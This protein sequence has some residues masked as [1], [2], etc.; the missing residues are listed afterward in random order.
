MTSNEHTMSRSTPVK[1]EPHAANRRRILLVDDDHEIAESVSYALQACGYEVLIAR[2][3]NQGLAMAEREDPDLVILDM[4]MPKRSG[5]LVLEKLRRTRPVPLRVIMITANEGSRHMAY[6]EMLG[7]DDYIRKPFAMD[8]L[9]QSVARLFDDDLPKRQANTYPSWQQISDLDRSQTTTFA[10]RSH[11][12]MGGS[13]FLTLMTAAFAEIVGGFCHDIRNRISGLSLAIEEPDSR[14]QRIRKRA[15]DAGEVVL[16]LHQFA[17]NYYRSASD[18]LVAIPSDS[19]HSAIRELMDQV[20]DG[21]SIEP[22]VRVVGLAKGFSIPKALLRQLLAPLVENASE[23]L[24]TRQVKGCIAVEIR[25]FPDDAIRITV[26]DNGPGWNQPVQTIEQQLVAERPFSTK[27]THRGHGLVN[28][29]RVVR[30]IRGGLSIDTAL[31]GGARIEITVRREDAIPVVDLRSI[32]PALTTAIA[33][34]TGAF[35]H[36][37]ANNLH[38]VVVESDNDRRD[39]A[40][41]Q[42][43]VRQATNAVIDLHQF[44][45]QHYRPDAVPI[46]HVPAIDIAVHLREILAPLTNGS[47]VEV[48][49]DTTELDRRLLF[50]RVLLRHL[51]LPIVENS[52]E[53]MFSTKTKG[54]VSVKLTSPVPV[55]DVMLSIKD[56]GPGFGEFLETLRQRNLQ[57]EAFSTKDKARGHGLQNLSRLVDRM[58]GELSVGDAE[59]GGALVSAV[60]P[61]E[62]F[63]AAASSVSA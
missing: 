29:S 49:I 37:V 24:S 23:A 35:C 54:I 43:C 47:S 28:L 53:A 2:D 52:V 50:P 15:L 21:Y 36:D 11:R 62:V 38:G 59:S 58:N 44:V 20:V 46:A 14:V 32:P 61:V 1:S 42:R 26:A 30:A 16:D 55:T 33:E 8:R 60:L 9:L 51:I 40:L 56:N 7:V 10:D 31:S 5:F 25:G 13:G 34:I 27:G 19:I 41:M 12:A 48:A 6:A 22:V 3:G 63:S 4:M 39:A 18:P 17:R 45:R 57:G